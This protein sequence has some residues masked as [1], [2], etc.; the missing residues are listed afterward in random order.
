MSTEFGIL[1]PLDIV[2]ALTDVSALHYGSVCFNKSYGWQLT[3][4]AEHEAM[5]PQ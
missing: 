5:L 3:S 4:S 2:H 1:A